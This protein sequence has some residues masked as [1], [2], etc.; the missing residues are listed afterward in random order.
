MNTRYLLGVPLVTVAVQEK[1]IE[2]IVDTGFNASLLLPISTIKELG[3]RVVGSARYCLADGRLSG[4]SI[5]SGEVE[6][7][8]R[9]RRVE[10]ISSNSEFPL[11]GMELLQ[12]AKTI[13][14]P[15]KN[16]LSIEHLTE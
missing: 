12:E 14:D 15:Q 4:T 1:E 16:F 3:L 2:A 7:L 8:G 13:L 11:V 5:F 6:W 10:I 9:K